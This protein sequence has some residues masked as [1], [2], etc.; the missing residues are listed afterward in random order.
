MPNDAEI[1]KYFVEVINAVDIPV[2]L[3]NVPKFTGYSVNPKV[4]AKIAEECS[5]LVA[6][7]DSSG[8][9]GNMAEVIRL[10]GD[11]INCLSGSAD[12]MLPT[13]MLGGKGAIVAIGN[14]VPKEC[15]ELYKAY[16]SGDYSAAGKYQ[17]TASYVNKV[18]VRELPQI[19]AI[20]TALNQKGFNAGVPR[21][22]LT[23]L[24]EDAKQSIMEAMKLI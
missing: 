24:S 13:L 11:K 17:R 6:M 4:V 15:A 10:C 18:L 12:M 22:P 14:V 9:P 19:A 23:G 16:K 7:K 5:G 8:N 21:K 3:Y 1:T 2:I 20:K